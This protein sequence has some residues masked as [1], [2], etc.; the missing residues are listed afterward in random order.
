MWENWSYSDHQG[1]QRDVRYIWEHC[2][3]FD[4]VTDCAAFIA[5]IKKC[6]LEASLFFN[7]STDDSLQEQLKA[8]YLKQEFTQF[9]I[10]HQG[11]SAVEIQQDF[12]AFIARVQPDNLTAP[13]WPPGKSTP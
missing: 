4:K 3:A 5:Y 13:T 6:Q 12:K 11:K 7:G 1:I 10:E 8:L 9:A 2:V